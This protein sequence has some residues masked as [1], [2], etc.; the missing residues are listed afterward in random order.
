[1]INDYYNA[2]R[3]WKLDNDNLKKK[4]NKSWNWIL[5]FVC[6]FLSEFIINILSGISINN[7]FFGLII[8][9]MIGLPLAYKNKN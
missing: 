1:M 4:K 9:S 8:G 3:N 7:F 6:L 2:W 5:F